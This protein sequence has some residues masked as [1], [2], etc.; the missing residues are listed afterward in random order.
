LVWSGRSYAFDAQDV[1]TKVQSYA[2]KL[3]KE[4]LKNGVIAY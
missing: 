3:F 1:E 2:K 4:L